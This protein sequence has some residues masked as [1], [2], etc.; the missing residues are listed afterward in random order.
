MPD[1]MKVRIEAELNIEV[2]F[3]IVRYFVEKM[4]DERTQ[5]LYWK[6]NIAEWGYPEEWERPMAWLVQ[7]VAD[8]YET[9]GMV[10]YP[11]DVPFRDH[12]GELEFESERV[13]TRNGE[14]TGY[15]DRYWVQ[16]DFD[17]LVNAVPWLQKE[18][19]EVPVTGDP[20]SEPLFPLPSE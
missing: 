4:K 7:Q 13:E 19:P 12:S 3:D 11:R 1:E 16:S 6:L 20:P 8:A 15:K 2:E 14:R 5:Q 9:M 10:A 17:T 18:S